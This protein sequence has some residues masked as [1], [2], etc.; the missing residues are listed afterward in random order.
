MDGKINPR[1]PQSHVPTQTAPIH[2]G[3]LGAS[4]S[5]GAGGEVLPAALPSSLNGGGI[6]DRFPALCRPG[7]PPPF[8]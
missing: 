7:M 3:H 4:L 2:R 5:I 1:E 8:F 6:C